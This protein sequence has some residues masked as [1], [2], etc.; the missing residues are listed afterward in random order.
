M[1]ACANTL[2]VQL[3]PTKMITMSKNVVRVVFYLDS[4]H[5]VKTL[6]TST[7]VSKTKRGESN[8]SS[9]SAFGCAGS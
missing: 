5:H 8:G 4:R 1:L 3:S 9:G 2:G 6:V 7:L